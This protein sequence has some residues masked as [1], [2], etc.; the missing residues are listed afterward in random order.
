MGKRDK[1]SGNEAVSIAMKQINPDVVA[2]FPI[3]PSTEV[4]QYF[5][6]F[7]NNGAVT[8]EFVP[9]ES[10]H[11]AM[12]ACIGASAAGARA[13]TAT[14]SNGMSLMWE[15]LYIA[16]GARL[17][18]VLNLINRAVSAPLNIHNDHSDSMG[19]R[20]SGWIQLYAENNQEAYDNMLMANRIAEHKDVMLPVMNCQDGFITSHS[21][22]NIEL[23]DDEDVKRFVGEYHPESYL[24]NSKQ[25]IAVGP[26]S[27]PTH[28]FE[29]KRAQAEAMKKARDVIMQV[30]KEF[31]DMTGR[32]YGNIESYKVEDADRVMVI[33]NSS[34]GTAKYVA[35]RLREKGEKVGVVKVRV[36]RP[37]P[38]I[39]LREVL[40][41]CKAVAVMD[42]TDSC[43]GNGGPLFT[44][45]RSALYDVETRP[46]MI[47][48][49]YGIGGRDV[50]ATDLES[51][52][53]DLKEVANG[54]QG[55]TYRYLGVY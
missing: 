28:T 2:A 24:L 50:K 10:E 4:P 35:D 8:T 46:N 37:F 30:S 20:D 18:I 27:L 45:T 25:P 39:D 41:N 33:M 51:V 9:V 49:I 38:L 36:F 14:S 43:N 23:V 53:E 16:A 22:E 34:A 52:F 31:G 29:Q 40:K 21:I 15:M 26:L 42:K 5:S 17:P 19:A 1:L 48:Y 44:E 32:Y 47:N 7:V 13:M 11:S 12:S 3:T 6:A 55:E 54:N